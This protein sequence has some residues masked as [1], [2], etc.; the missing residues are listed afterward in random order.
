MS[1]VVCCSTNPTSNILSTSLQISMA[2]RVLHARWKADDLVGRVA[3]ER[4]AGGCPNLFDALFALQSSLLNEQILPP[5]T[6]AFVR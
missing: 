6:L 1:T 4:F 3:R 2:R 5:P